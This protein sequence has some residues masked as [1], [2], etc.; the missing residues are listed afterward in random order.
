[1]LQRIDGVSLE[2]F[3]DRDVL[4]TGVA[5]GPGNKLALLIAEKA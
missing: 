2:R 3:V 5:R 1:V 4:H